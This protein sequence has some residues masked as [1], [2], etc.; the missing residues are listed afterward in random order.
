M[1]L[2]GLL[3]FL[4]VLEF[5]VEAF[6]MACPVCNGAG[7]WSGWS[8]WGLCNMQ[9]GAYS[10]QRIRTCSNSNCYGAAEESQACTV[11]RDPPVAAPQWNSWQPWSGCSV[12]C[13]GGVESRTR[14]CNNQCSVC[15]C[16]GAATEQRPCNPDPCCSWL[17]WS[18]WSECSVTCG[19]GGV[20]H[21]TRQCS[22]TSCPYGESSQQETCSGPAACPITCNVCNEPPPPPPPTCNVCNPPPPPCSACGYYGRRKRRQTLLDRQ[23]LNGNSALTNSTV[24]LYPHST[25]IFPN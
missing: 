15:Q 18:P 23:I 13:G 11:Q 3:K 10:K 4:F 2:R 12:S 22:C 5:A 17:Q 6:G 21:R 1:E 8:E 19:E 20:R 14:T 16:Q 24:N 9:Y 25:G 7:Q